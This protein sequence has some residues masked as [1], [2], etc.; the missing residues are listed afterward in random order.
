MKGRLAYAKAELP[1]SPATAWEEGVGG[2]I[3]TAMSVATDILP[4][5]GADARDAAVAGAPTG[6]A[7]SF[8]PLL[9]RCRLLLLLL[10][11]TLTPAANAG[12]AVPCLTDLPPRAGDAAP[13]ARSRT[14][15]RPTAIPA[16]SAASDII[17]AEVKP[18][19]RDLS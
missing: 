13:P 16:R 18:G 8:G 15:A 12:T 10:L 7:L 6:G 9:S 11:L 3:A 19:G 1:P 17:S 2:T 14:G 5:L 4:G